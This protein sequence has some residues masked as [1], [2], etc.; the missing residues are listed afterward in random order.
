MNSHK[1]ERLL[2]IKYGRL[3]TNNAMCYPSFI[4]NKQ[5]Y[6]PFGKDMDTSTDGLQ[7][8][9]DCDHEEYTATI[10]QT[11]E[12]TS[13]FDDWIKNNYK[14]VDIG[15]SATCCQSG[16]YALLGFKDD[17]CKFS[18]KLKKIGRTV[19]TFN[20]KFRCQLYSDQLI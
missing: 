4:T 10:P 20:E 16:A 7:I 13:R 1:D 6:G 14:F 5:T 8:S 11:A 2:Q 17:R 3:S 15:P 12:Y 9:S 18:K 19:F